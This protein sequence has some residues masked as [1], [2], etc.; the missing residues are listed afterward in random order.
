VDLLGPL[1]RIKI[2][3]A[4]REREPVGTSVMLLYKDVAYEWYWGAKIIK[5]LYPAEFLTW[6]RI[7]WAK[8][9]GFSLYDFGGAGWPDQPYGVRD[10][11]AKFGGELVDYGRYR[12]VFC[13]W[14]F[15]FAESAYEFKRRI[16][17][18]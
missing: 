8:R 7:E 11:K 18:H 3:I 15:R 5:S 9:N 12:K 13:P 10:F 14:K 1:E 6:H 17:G 2:F 16:S 4:Y